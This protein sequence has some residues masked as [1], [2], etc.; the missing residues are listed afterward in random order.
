MFAFL[1]VIDIRS[2]KQKQ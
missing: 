1:S 2:R